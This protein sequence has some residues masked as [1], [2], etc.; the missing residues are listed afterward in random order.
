M[1]QRESYLPYRGHVRAAAASGGDV[2]FVTEH[3]EGQP[4]ALYRLD[5]DALT[6][7]EQALPCGGLALALDGTTAFVAGTD[8]RVYAAS[9]SKAP[10]PLAGPFDAAAVALVPVAGDRLAVL[11]G[12]Q[13]LLVSRADG[14]VL[15]TLPLPER[16][17]ALA[18]DRSGQWLA[19]GTEKG[20]VAVFDGQDRDAFEAAESGKLH[21]GAV[22]ALLFELEELRFFSAGADHKLLTTHARGRLEPE[23]KGRANTHD[24]AVTAMLFAPAGDR[25]LTGGKDAVV[26][27]WPR[28]GGVQPASLK[29]VV[30]RVVALA[31]VAVHTRHRLAAACDDDSIRFVD[32]DA[33]GRFGEPAGRA[34]GAVDRA[35]FEFGQ[36]DPKRRERTLRDLAGWNDAASVDLLASR[37]TAD[38]DH[39]LRLLAAQLLAASPN[40][41]AVAP[42]EAAVTHADE[43][44][45]VAA[46]GGLQ[47]HL[48]AGDFR[49]I[50]LALKADKADVGVLAVKALEPLAA[51]DDQAL[52]RL[53]NALNVSTWDVRRAALSSLE[54]VFGAASPEA[55]LAALGST[56]GDVRAA[57]LVRFFER[58]Q[59]GD[60]R[61]KAAARRRLE[62]DDAGVRRVAFL[63]TVLSR[64]ALARVLRAAD[65]ELHRQLNELE[66]GD[67]P[68]ADVK[69]KDRAALTADDLDVPL[70][71]TAA[72][73]LDTCL[74]G[75]RALAVLGDPRAFGL[76]VQLSREENVS[77][78]VDV[79]RALAALAD[80]R[81]V[82][83]LRS[84][85][86][87][88]DAS[89]RD[90][91]YSALVKIEAASPL[92]VAE[93]G[94]T[95]AAEDVRRRGLQTLVEA[96]R[97]SPPAGP[98]DPA[99]PLLAR[100][101][102]DAA[103]GVRLEAWKAALNLKVGGGGEATLRFARG[104]A[105]VDV[106]REVLTEVGAGAAEPWA[107]PLL[108]EF[109]NDPD[110]GLRAEAFAQATRKTKDLAP[111][112]AALASRF[113]DSRLAAIDALEKKHTKPA[114]SLLARALADAD[115]DNRR[116]A[117]AALVDEDARGPLADALAGG[118]ADVRA[119]AAAALARHGDAAALAPLLALASAP[120]PVEKERVPAWLESTGV[121]MAGLADL[122]DPAAV[123][124]VRPLLDSP[125]AALRKGAAE[126]LA[127]SAT[128][129]TADVLRGTLS[130]ADP[131]VRGRAV[132]GLAHLGD[133]GVVG[134]LLDPEVA[135]AVGANAILAAAVALGAAGERV[136]AAFLDHADE[137]VR[138]QALLV[139]MLAELR[140]PSGDAR[141][142]LECLS[143]RA[144]RTRLAAAQGLERYADPAAFRD[145]VVKLM[146]DRGDDTAWK[147]APD[148]VDALA[149]VLTGGPPAVRARAVGL[150][151]TLAH[152]EQAGWNQAWAAFGRRFAADI[153]A[154]ASTPP[155][156]AS[157]VPADA[158][159]ELAF[160][161]YI[162]LVREQGGAAASPAV[163]R[164]RQTALARV[165]AVASADDRYRRAAQPVFVQSLSDPNQP[166]RFQA[167]EHL[168]ALNFDRTR[169]GAEA[170]ESGHTDLGVKGLELLTDGTTSAA[171]D[172]VLEGVV[173]SRTDDLATEAAKL[174]AGRR[175]FVPVATLALGAA[176][177]PLRRQAVRWLAA[178]YDAS[179][180]A[181]KA[182]R[183]ALASRYA[184]VREAAAFELAAKKDVAAFDALVVLLKE[185]HDEK[186]QEAVIDA[187]LALDDSRAPDAFLDRVE[188]DPT[189]TANAQY[190]FVAAGV[191]RRPEN[192]DRIVAL[193][194]RKKEWRLW[195][196][197]ALNQ[198]SGFDQDVA[199]PDDERP[200][201]R[202]WEAKQHPRRPAVL[203]RLLAKLVQYGG[204]EVA[205]HIRSARWC[206]GPEVDE[207]LVAFAESPDEDVRR[208]AVE[209]V[210]WRVKHR[211]ASPDPL[212]K[213]LRHKD[214][215]T[216]FVAAEGLAL[217]GRAEGVHVLL[218]A[219]DFLDDVGMRG[220]AVAAL[221][222]LGDARGLDLLLKLAG[223][224]GH[225][226][227]EP[228]AE[229]IGHL[230]RSP[231]ADRIGRLLERLAKGNGG[232]ARRALVGLRW[233]DSPEG[234][235]LLRRR[236]ADQQSWHI[237]QTAVEQ[238]GRRDDPANRDALMKA[239]RTDTDGDVLEKAF[240]AARRLWGP[241]SLEPHFALIQN[242]R[243]DDIT[244]DTDRYGEDVLKAVCDRGDALEILRVFPKCDAEV[245]GPLEASLLARLTLP[246]V[247]ATAA[248]ASDD[249]GTVRL[250][251]RLVA[252]AGGA[253]KAA[254]KAVAAALAK[255]SAEWDARRKKHT[256]DEDDDGDD[257]DPTPLDRAGDC[258]RGLVWAAGRLGAADAVAG[259]ATSRAD[260]V[261]F[262]P[263]RL[264]AVRGLAS[265]EPSKAGLAALEA[266]A[267]G[268]D[269]AARTL[270]ADALGRLAPDRAAKLLE[271]LAS[272]RP[273]FA[274]LV[275]GT[276]S[277]AAAAF[278]KTAAGQ[279][280][281]Q[282]VALPAVIAAKDVPTLAAVAKDRKKPEAARLGAVEGLGAMAAEPAER[283]LAEVGAADGDD[284][285]VRKAAWRALRRSKRARLKVK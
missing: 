169:L 49:P 241:D 111:L 38:A 243:A 60:A 94:L 123:P 63:L 136:V 214:P 173:L 217:A 157:R 39:H 76:L 196:L 240:A 26:K 172:G 167:F 198:I 90:A 46:F 110:P 80:P 193:A 255:W 189:G 27:T 89:V 115:R 212:L 161:A 197:Q 222:E 51:R 236:A 156:T 182:L 175:G 96:A 283:V 83:R 145:F 85:L 265:G 148:V 8:K 141:R 225:A 135:A 180:P 35:K 56:H 177:D 246:V 61:V 159:R 211:G 242:S 270:A 220:R 199:D 150:L 263:V 81:A 43:K 256:P 247:E 254:A 168:Q 62:D 248:L 52:A 3:P 259:V 151:A 252:R 32:L 165:L 78:R 203:A 163:V 231:A 230:R 129:A 195:A 235:Q 103:P 127:W 170:L 134:H 37:L 54:G 104:S 99:W 228:A 112:E 227:Q 92:T 67:R 200:H 160:G 188:T 12:S 14:A 260:D 114:Q 109:L 223:E 58:D 166:V 152:K 285:D 174:L 45:R 154:A 42:L 271:A 22:T 65:A 280:H 84:L 213:A 23:D 107:T 153:S 66:K 162:G 19:A 1:S 149:A 11:A 71:A 116:R 17:T 57:A 274:R 206:R 238:L 75:A 138:G 282:P 9:G 21:D 186:R 4:T 119:G 98:T 249:E 55:G 192:A 158:L 268:T 137:A 15:Q 2:L 179:A 187:L 143:A 237:R 105:H 250:A 41:R 194:D 13:L 7:S 261:F 33:E 86:F 133:A 34:Y 132:L 106:R 269:P 124:A 118:H 64:A 253:D 28:A 205:D 233:F 234:W 185:A 221:G 209:A 164:V 79:C 144:P 267:R 68:A 245:Q 121:A 281:Y 140:D 59:L 130:H 20:T 16:G 273:S 24:D 102:D 258:L 204:F 219:V 95:A 74:R 47:K 277:A 184:K 18:A 191:Y 31:V 50:D 272:D 131:E 108:F 229:A 93:S 216:Q 128:P 100:A 97:K 48:G 264:E 224:D 29:D 207:P 126:A 44:V 239:L 30:G 226:L 77:A 251:A 208:Q 276:G 279:V 215:T 218:S 232:V 262:R 284:D 139:E 40:P 178:E 201:D 147:V 120:E 155:R 10:K 25:L 69:A 91:A 6:L 53:T 275:A 190:M 183:D 73:A 117:L 142:C 88:P 146:N 181:Q 176:H 278:V 257:G 70:Q 122:A 210:G 202:A 125:H 72:R 113:A 266:V 244:D 87:D 101:L 36:H 171:G 82:A 5:A